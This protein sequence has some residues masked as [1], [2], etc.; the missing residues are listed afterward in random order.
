MRIIKY[1]Y[2]RK[3]SGK[4]LFELATANLNIKLYLLVSQMLL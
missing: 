3:I 4:S 1:E 2:E